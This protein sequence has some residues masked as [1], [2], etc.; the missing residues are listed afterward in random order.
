VSRS[1]WY[2]RTDDHAP[3]EDQRRVSVTYARTSAFSE[4][5]HQLIGHPSP[6]VGPPPTSRQMLGHSSAAITM[7]VYGHL[8]ND[9]LDEVADALDDA[10]S[11][12]A[13]SAAAVA[14]AQNPVAKVFRTP[15]WSTWPPT[16]REVKPQVR[17]QNSDG[18]PARFELA[19]PP[20]EHQRTMIWHDWDSTKPRVS[21]DFHALAL[22][23][24]LGRFGSG[25]AKLLPK[26]HLGT[27]ERAST[28]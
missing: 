11:E 1:A 7:D 26:R 2:V 8:F 27:S 5:D 16:R 25:V 13:K 24:V 17:R 4:L 20:P 15:M 23:A 18:T 3:I 14:N 9:R 10:R 12:A 28:V 21:P 22:L 19:L 6:N